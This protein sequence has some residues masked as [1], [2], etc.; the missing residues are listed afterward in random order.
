MSAKCR[1]GFTLI[2]LLVVIAI[3][4]VLIALLL[5][6]V[7]AAREAARRSQCTNNLKQIAL[8][9]HNYHGAVGSFPLAH[10]HPYANI[11]DTGYGSDWG[12]WSAHSMLLPYVEQKPVYDS[13]NFVWTNWWGYGGDTNVGANRTAE[14]TRINSFL[15][16]S[17]GIETTSWGEPMISN[18]FACMGTTTDAGN[19]GSTGIFTPRNTSYKESSIKDGLSNTILF[20]E[21]LV[22]S[23]ILQTKYRDAVTGASNNGEYNP[24]TTL[25]G[26]LVIDAN[27]Q[28]ALNSCNQIWQGSS[29]H[30]WYK[31]WRW[32]V[33]QPGITI[34]NTIVT[35]NS[36]QYQWGTCRIGCGGC[37]NDDSAFTTANSGHPGGVNVALADG[38]V[39]FIKDTVAP[40]VWW[41]L[42]T[43]AGGE[44]LSADQY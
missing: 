1:K 31:G 14:N 23:D 36:K 13:I 3:I 25:N 2:E 37:G 20:S 35:P 27:T 28:S 44:A 38:S 26:Q 22:G 10:T 8:A 16:P 4:G 18:Y 39:R 42:G 5:P 34:M 9:C 43:K 7:Q 41:S 29:N 19:N 30:N 24:I 21:G 12:G 6:A 33:G 17:D 40:Q 15:C 32:A 11:G